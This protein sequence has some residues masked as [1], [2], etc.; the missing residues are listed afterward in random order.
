MKNTN[1]W[2]RNDPNKVMKL[3]EEE[4]DQTYTRL[5]KYGQNMNG[6]RAETISRT[7]SG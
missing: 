7:L 3:T 4:C 2:Y 1:Q 5:V 6:R